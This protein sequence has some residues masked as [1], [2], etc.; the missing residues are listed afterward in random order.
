MGDKFNGV[1]F[2]IDGQTFEG[3]TKAAAYIK[4]LGFTTTES[5]KY[6]DLLKADYT[7]NSN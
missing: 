5:K 1:S 6:L 3:S 7:A 2:V 4:S